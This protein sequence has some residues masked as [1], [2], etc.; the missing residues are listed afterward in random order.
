MYSCSDLEKCGFTAS[1][2]RPLGWTMQCSM[3][4]DGEGR[5]AEIMQ[6]FNN[7][8]PI[9]E[10]QC[11]NPHA[12]QPSLINASC[13]GVCTENLTHSFGQLPKPIQLGAYTECDPND[14]TAA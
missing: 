10:E 2:Q 14:L 6:R 13:H 8:Q 7:S 9:V 12:F 11:K 4:L 5:F 1:T 3:P